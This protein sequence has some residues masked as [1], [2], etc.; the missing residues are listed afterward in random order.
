MQKN[1][2]IILSIIIF[3]GIGVFGLMYYTASSTLQEAEKQ[4]QVANQQQEVNPGTGQEEQLENEFDSSTMESEKAEPLSNDEES[5]A[6]ENAQKEQSETTNQSGTGVSIIPET[7]TSETS[8]ITVT[9]QGA[10][11]ISGFNTV[12]EASE[13]I[14][15]NSYGNDFNPNGASADD[16][17][18][19]LT[20]ISDDGTTAK[21]S[22][23]TLSLGDEQLP[24]EITFSLNVTSSTEDGTISLNTND[25]EMVGP[26]SVQYSIE[27]L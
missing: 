14:T 15:I 8:E 1:V 13:G 4:Q 21:I 19:V 17:S 6:D 5:S 7:V 11:G 26:E 12:L 20:F 3:G 10:E 9:L 22:F 27:S 24:S 25:S 2:I 18:E 23:V 16:F